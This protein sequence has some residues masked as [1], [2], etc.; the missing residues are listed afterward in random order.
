[1]DK[2]E[3][4]EDIKDNATLAEELED[5]LKEEFEKVIDNPTDQQ[6]K[7]YRDIEDALLAAWLADTMSNM[8]SGINENIKTGKSNAVEQ[9]RPKGFKKVE[10]NEKIY[11]ELSNAKKQ[12]VR[13][14]LEK[15]VAGIKQ[16]SRN[17]IAEMR[18]AFILQKKKLTSGFMDTFKKYGVAYF[19]DRA[20][21]RWTLKRYVD[22]ATTTVLASTSRQAFFA[23]S[24][25]WGNDLVRVY[26]IGLTPECPLCAPFTGKV[27]SI[28]GKT[29]GY[30]T[31]DEAS[32]SGHL[33]SY[34]CDHDI[35]ALELAPEKQEGDNK[36]ALTDKNI[37]YM[38][39]HGLKNI[40]RKAYYE[41]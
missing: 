26:H 18:D 31:V 36:I 14:D 6:I 24:L 5:R 3:I 1:M 17:N 28:A 16:N 30:M 10:D 22:M 15:I 21:R 20:N 41:K 12:Q 13:A 23:K 8:I 11:T 40:K 38:K 9:L 4:K 29:R 37:E 2:Q 34:N 35:A 27:L 39:K 32:Q 25:E 19:T 7:K 33:F